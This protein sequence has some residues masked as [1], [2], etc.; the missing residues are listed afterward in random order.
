MRQELQ[1]NYSKFNSEDID[2]IAPLYLAYFNEVESAMW[3]LETATRKLRQL[4]HREDVIAYKLE[5]HKEL[6]G[7]YVG[8]LLQFDDGL[9]FELLELLVLRE[10]QNQGF[11]SL[12]LNRAIE[13]AKQEGAFMIQ[14]TSAVDEE[15]FH[16]YNTKHGFLDAKNNV[17]K[18]KTF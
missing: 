6:I 15:H 8:Q 16:F 18:T 9:V 5:S 10:Y 1:K 13:D 2:K 12:L 17:W 7:F 3:T 4:I 11:G 14:L